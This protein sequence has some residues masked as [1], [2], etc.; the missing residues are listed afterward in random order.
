MFDTIVE[1]PADQQANG[2]I[3]PAEGPCCYLQTALPRVV[4][5]VLSLGCSLSIKHNSAQCRKIA[6]ISVD[7]D[8]VI[9][10]ITAA[11]MCNISPR[12]FDCFNY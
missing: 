6:P 1:G 12:K 5:Q 10:I 11:L 7:N 2:L 8:K 9:I 3:A 4:N